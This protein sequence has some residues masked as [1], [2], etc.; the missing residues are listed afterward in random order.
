MGASGH[1]ASWEMESDQRVHPIEMNGSSRPPNHNSQEARWHHFEFS[2]FVF[3]CLFREQSIKTFCGEQT[4][5]G[6][7]NCAARASLEPM[8]STSSSLPPPLLSTAPNPCGPEP[9]SLAH[10]CLAFGKVLELRPLAG[11]CTGG[12][13]GVLGGLGCQDRPARPIQPKR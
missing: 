7:P 9:L 2:S 13:A 3:W 4:L 1:G 6:K 11:A 8:F 12:E 10:R 5:P